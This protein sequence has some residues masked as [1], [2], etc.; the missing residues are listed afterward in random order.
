MIDPA[1][2]LTEVWA[3]MEEQVEKGRT[4]AIGL[5]N[6]NAKQISR[7]LERNKIPIA[8]LQVEFHVYFQQKELV[9]FCKKNNIAMTAYSPLGSR[10]L[11]K[12]M[13]A[14][15]QHP[16]L[17]NNPVVLELSAKYGKLPAQI[18]LKHTVQ[19][20]IAVI[21]KSTNSRRLAENINIFGWSL[22]NEDM[23]KLCALDCGER[24]RI[25]DFGFLKGI[26]KHPEFPF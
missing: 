12:A 15:A 26:E 6:F 11:V 4:K 5:S 24:G 7:V 14:T 1:T 22:E 25:C 9:K 13:G 20:G 8:S 2:N 19:K 16:D 10:G 18:L 23:E 17:L 21:P 3:K